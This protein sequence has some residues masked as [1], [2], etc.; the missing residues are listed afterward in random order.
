MIKPQPEWLGL[1]YFMAMAYLNMEC[2][3]I[4]W[5]DFEQPKAGPKGG[6]QEAR[7]SV[8]HCQALIMKASYRCDARLFLWENQNFPQHSTRLVQKSCIRIN[9]VEPVDSL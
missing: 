4:A 5:S 8:G 2:D 7:S 3:K 9:S 1:F 6:G